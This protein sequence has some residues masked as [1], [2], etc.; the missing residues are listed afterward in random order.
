MKMLRLCRKIQSDIS[1]YRF[2]N[3]LSGTKNISQ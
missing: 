1:Q 3:S 2:L